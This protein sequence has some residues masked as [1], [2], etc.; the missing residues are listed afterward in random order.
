MCAKIC[1]NWYQHI[2]P[3]LPADWAKSCS[4]PLMMQK[5]NL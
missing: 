3:N 2:Q 4:N 5:K 1:V